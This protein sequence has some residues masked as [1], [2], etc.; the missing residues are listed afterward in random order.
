MNIDNFR[1]IIA[2]IIAH[3][4]T[5]TQTV[6]HSECGTKHSLAGWAQRMA[7]YPLEPSRAFKDAMAWLE[8]DVHDAR[9]LFDEERTLE[10]F[11]VFYEERKCKIKPMTE[12][13]LAGIHIKRL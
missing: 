1:K 2:Q 12:Y 4:E 13:F 8:L 10:D 7:G 5:F 11:K 6:C 3:P 9:Y